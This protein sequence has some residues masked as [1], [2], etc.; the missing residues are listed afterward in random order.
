VAWVSYPGLPDHPSH[1]RAL[2]Y[3][4]EGAGAILTFGIKGAFTSPIL[5]G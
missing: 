5:M 2:R 1:E 4:P 3:L